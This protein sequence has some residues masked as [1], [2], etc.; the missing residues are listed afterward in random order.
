M[1]RVGI[2]AHLF[3]ALFLLS[4]GAICADPVT[5]DGETDIGGL[6]EQ[7]GAAFD[8]DREDAVAL[9]EERREAWTADGR[10]VTSVHAVVWAGTAHGV[11]R[12]ADLR[13]PWDSDRQELTVA[14]LRTWRLADEVWIDSGETA[15]VDTLPFAVDD[16]PPYASRRETMLLH[17]GVEVPCI[18]ETAYTITDREPFRGGFDGARSLA[19][20]EPAVRSRLVLAA[21]DGSRLR[22]KAGPGVPAPA[23]KRDEREDLATLTFEVGPIGPAARP[24]TAAA[25]AAAPWVTWSTWPSWPELGIAVLRAFEGSLDLDDALRARLDEQVGDARTATERTRLAAEM[26]A[27]GTRAVHADA[28]WW[29]PPRPARETWATACGHPVDRAVLAAALLRAAGAR[30]QLLYRAPGYGPLPSEL[31]TLAWLD[32]PFLQVGTDQARGVVDPRSGRMSETPV[33]ADG[34]ILW[35]PGVDDAPVP[36]DG[37]PNGADLALRLDV[38]FD[39][40]KDAWVGTGVLAAD[41]VMSPYPAM[42]GLDGQA[43]AELRRIAGAVL[44]GA[45]VSDYNPERFTPEEVRVGFTVSVPAGDRD[46]LGRLRLDV[47]DP[48]PVR[49]LLDEE[50]VRLH[51]AERTAPADLPLPLHR[52]VELYVDPGDLDVVRVPE[53]AEATGPVGTFRLKSAVGDGSVSVIRVLAVGSGAVPAEAWPELRALL[54]ADHDPAGR[55]LLFAPPDEE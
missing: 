18:L 13:I 2:R 30:A 47:G 49:A 54:L 23:E 25:R 5:F 24:A 22:W 48:G 43:L 32:G 39:A 14:T 26:L 17:D 50:R 4:S 44:A 42:T 12:W 1:T 53:A 7:A 37:A 9:L 52:R 35:R 20:A 31:P 28:G 45:E 15:I 11:R 33:E 6:L 3:S 38:R 41:G 27:D 34:R 46:D 21:P 40:E 16:A 36:H 19:L 55:V 8:L 29:P 10:R 51:D